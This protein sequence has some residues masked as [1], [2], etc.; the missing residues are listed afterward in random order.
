M[1]K[2]CVDDAFT[3][4]FAIDMLLLDLRTDSTHTESETGCEQ[5]SP[6]TNQQSVTFIVGC[7]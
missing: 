7:D 6:K 5:C 2:V 1:V 3:F 4:S